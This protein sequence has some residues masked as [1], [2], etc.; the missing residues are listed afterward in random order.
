MKRATTA[1]DLLTDLFVIRRLS[2]VSGVPGVRSVATALKRSSTNLPCSGLGSQCATKK[3]W[4]LT[5][6]RCANLAVGLLLVASI[7]LLAEER[8]RQHPLE[9]NVEVGF[10]NYI[11]PERPFPLLV[12]LSAA[13][14]LLEGQIRVF[15]ANSV[16]GQTIYATPF[17][18]APNARK[19]WEFILPPIA[20]NVVQ[21]QVLERNGTPLRDEQFLGLPVERGTPLVLLVQSGALDRYSLPR[22]SSESGRT[23]RVASIDAEF[24]PE[25]PLA[26]AGVSAV[27]WRGDKDAALRETQAEA[28]RS[29]LAQGGLLVVAG[30]RSVPPNLPNGFRFGARWGDTV[31]FDLRDLANAR[32]LP[33]QRPVTLPVRWSAAPDG[34]PTL[35]ATTI[36]IRPLVGER[37]HARMH[38]NGTK[39]LTEQIVGG[40][41]LMQLAFD[42]QDI[43]AQD[44]ELGRTFWERALCLP[45][46]RRAN[47][48]AWPWLVGVAQDPNHQRLAEIAE[49]RVESVWKIGWMFGAFF[50]L[51][52]C[53][54]FWLFRKSRRYEWAW[55]ILI[56][57]SVGMFLYNRALGRVGGFGPIRHF[58]QTHSFGVAGEKTVLNFTETGLLAPSARHVSIATT[59]PRQMFVSL[60]AE[61]RPVR[62]DEKRQIYSVRLKAGAFTTCSSVGL[63]ELPGDGI[64]VRWSGTNQYVRLAISNR[65]GLTLGSPQFTPSLGGPVA[66]TGNEY[67]VTVPAW[68][69]ENWARQAMAAQGPMANAPNQQMFFSS[70]PGS[71]QFP[72]Y[73]PQPRRAGLFG[74][75]TS[76][77]APVYQTPMPELDNPQLGPPAFRFE[78]PETAATTASGAREVRCR[79]TVTLFIPVPLDGG[80][81]QFRPVQ[82]QQGKVPPQAWKGVVR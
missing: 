5:T 73:Y 9:L 57:G 10:A 19:R 36:G 71:Y 41:V 2:A 53:L 25:N 6:S 11:P 8:K 82:P 24:L 27:V 20:G 54:N 18:L 68:A 37:V 50:A 32:L 58:E 69:F 16:G 67:V 80:G 33:P 13:V 64:G 40:G 51:A 79:R 14:R 39:L 17:S 7:S 52:F 12:E 42:P 22:P 43:A 21:V 75:R 47:W 34:T 60:D 55:L 56:V 49:Y 29:W 31:A 44:S 76:Y 45:D 77:V 15:G 23:W 72:A 62:L 4:G 1:A 65:T 61:D 28:L 70:Q 78:L 81:P 38:L 46:A 63:S 35:A 66:D 74:R 59:S 30:G 3:S 26:Y 48:A